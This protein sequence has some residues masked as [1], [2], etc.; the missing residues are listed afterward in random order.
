MASVMGKLD[1]PVGG[2]IVANRDSI[3]IVEQNALFIICFVSDAL[4][5]VLDCFVGPEKSKIYFGSILV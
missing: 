1:S 2:K 4:Y 5:R 3:E